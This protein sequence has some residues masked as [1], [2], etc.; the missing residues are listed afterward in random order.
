MSMTPEQIALFNK[1]HDEVVKHNKRVSSIRNTR[2]PKDHVV[3]I[4][5]A[6]RVMH[7]L[8]EAFT[9]GVYLG[10]NGITFDDMIELAN[11]KRTL[12][13]AFTEQKVPERVKQ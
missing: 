5:D 10:H 13:Q 3:A 1:R 2:L 4:D 6:I 12:E 9:D 7:N 8:H 11:V